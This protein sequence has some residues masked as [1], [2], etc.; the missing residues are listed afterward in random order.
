M[1]EIKPPKEAEDFIKFVDSSPSPFHAVQEAIKH[2]AAAGYEKIQERESWEKILKPNCK[3]YFTRNQSTLV[4]F[5]IGG[6]YVPGNGL[7]IVGAHTDSPCLK[8]KPISKKQSVGYLQVGVEPYG[9]GLWHTWFDRDL[10]VAGRVI[11]ESNN[12]TYYGKL[13]RISRPI[14][15]VPTLAIHLDREVNTNGFKFNKETHLTPLLATVTKNLDASVNIVNG[16]HPEPPNHHSVLLNILAKELNIKVEQIKDFELC[17]YDVHAATIGGAY[18]EFIFSARLDNLMM[19]YTALVALINSTNADEGRSLLDE[20]NIRMI[21]LFDNEEVG[22]ATAHGADSS[23]L[24]HT[25]RRLTLSKIGDHVMT[26]GTI[27]QETVQKSFLISADMAHAVHPNYAEKHEENHRPQMHKGVVIKLNANQRYAT[28]SVTSF[29]LREIAKK[30]KV[31]LQEFVVRA[32]SSCGSTIGPMISTNL[33]LRTVD[34]GN[35]Q[36]SM[37]SIREVSGTEDVVHAINLFE[38]FFEDFHEIDQRVFVD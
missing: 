21:A 10:S 18:N 20:P 6:K 12:N 15:R 11:I 8:L 30:R 36:L 31:P 19:S 37:H 25:I 17:L 2:L 22:S 3:Y 38:T 23:L 5:A 13:V 26:S 33:G 34:V 1:T 29:I 35:P 7:S 9:G 14:L 28:T 27:F 4:A 24:E 16:D 32:D